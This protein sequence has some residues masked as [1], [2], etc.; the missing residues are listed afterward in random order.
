MALKGDGPM[1]RVAELLDR[2]AAL[3]KGNGELNRANETL[4]HELQE[5]RYELEGYQLAI[6]DDE[7]MKHEI[8][9][10][11][12]F[13]ADLRLGIRDLSEYEEVCRRAG[14]VA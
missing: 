1:Q 7:W 13:I 5:A 9:A 2:V 6:R 4:A 11:R 8:D 14:L 10:L 3:E 12:E